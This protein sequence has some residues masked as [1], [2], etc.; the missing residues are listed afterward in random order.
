V[1][2]EHSVEPKRRV[3]EP[4]TNET[5]ESSFRVWADLRAAGQ[6]ATFD[7][8]QA[9]ATR[10]EVMAVLSAPELFVSGGRLDNGS[11]RRFIPQ[12]IDPPNHRRYRQ[13]LEPIFAPR[14]VR[15]MEPAIRAMAA[16]LVES[17]QGAG[18]CDFAETVAMLA[19]RYFV[20]ELLGMPESAIPE[21]MLLKDDI[22]HPE[23][24]NDEE[25][26]ATKMAGGARVEKMLAVSMEQRKQNLGTD[27]FS[28]IIQLR[29]DGNPLTDDEILAIYYQIFIAG[30][31]SV[32][33]MT[34]MMFRFLAGSPE[35]RQRIVTDPAVI[36]N[37]VEEMLRRETV[38]E[39]VARVAARDCELNGRTLHPGDQVVISLG[40]AN[41]D[42]DVFPS[43]EVVDFDRNA[44]QHLAFA[45]GIHRC[46]GSHLARL[47]LA[48]V[49][50][51]WHKRIPDY[52]IPEGT[53]L[54]WIDSP[55]RMVKALPLEWERI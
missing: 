23:G 4:R 7:G 29:L 17:V 52:W 38:V 11:S 37:A 45:G 21:M 8:C 1:N 46:L 12:E 33:A 14:E 50:E 47:E 10:D 15:R 53:E 54:E 2:S 42:P 51:E 43:A 31:D 34:T 40:A 41:H 24:A 5:L 13:L 26:Q 48:V 3:R 6:Q 49:L 32:M 44:N 9:V 18:H 35:H 55:I 16:E 27:L 19:P 36:P 22:L 30:L 28:Q 25:R 39:T 20:L